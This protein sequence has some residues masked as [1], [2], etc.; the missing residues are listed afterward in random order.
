[1]CIRDRKREG[2]GSYDDWVDRVTD[3]V[4]IRWYGNKSVHLLSNYAG[5]EPHD[6]CLRWEAKEN[7]YVDIE[8]PFVVQEYNKYM[9]RVDLADMLIKLYRINFKSR[10]WYTRIFYYLLDLSVVNAWL[11]YRRVHVSKGLLKKNM[12]LVDFKTDIAQELM[13]CRSSGTP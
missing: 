1:M 7:K 9:G 12:P 6:R 3:C 8:R 2:R 5:I 4:A 10:K 11:L 13:N